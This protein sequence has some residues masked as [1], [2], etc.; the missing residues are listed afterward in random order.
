VLIN[1]GD[2]ALWFLGPFPIRIRVRIT[3]MIYEKERKVAIE[4]VLSSC[5][6]CREVQDGLLL[7][8]TPDKGEPWD[9][10]LSKEDR[11]PVTVAD[12]G[13]QALISHYLKKTFPDD[14]LVGEE[15]A[16]LLRQPE[17][18]R[19]KEAVLDIVKRF[20]PDLSPTEVLD[21]IER[22]SGDG[23]PTG[24]FWTV[25][26][27]DGTKG[28]LRKDQYAVALALIEE[29]EVVLGVLGC[30]NL[31]LEGLDPA[32][33]RGSL[34]VAVRNEG[35]FIRGLEETRERKIGVDGVSDPAQAVFCES[36]ESSHSSHE[37]SA[38][39]AADLGITRPPILMDSLCKYGIVARGDASFY[40]RIPGRKLYVEKIW[41]HAAGLII[42][43]EAGG[44]VTD[45]DG[46]PLNFSLGRTLKANR[47]IVASNGRIHQRII[48][49]VKKDLMTE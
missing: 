3:T 7:R 43:L 44:I 41:D 13:S 6:L 28:F 14:N 30:P 45:I 48:D 34:F 49:T 20:F 23:S 5:E 18:L 24:R 4:A 40:I 27:I 35:T 25:D 19:I 10:T 37:D 33:I 46:R 2:V 21:A 17:N 12:F 29:G 22:G 38:K 1:I 15:N 36:V 9:G 42:V 16:R 47:G 31:P 32:G 8:G 26:P 39:I 11:S